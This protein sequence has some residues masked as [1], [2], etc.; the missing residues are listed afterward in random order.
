MPDLCPHG[1]AG[2]C[3]RCDFAAAHPDGDPMPP[4][5]VHPPGRDHVLCP[6][7]GCG[8]LM[9]D[10]RDGVCA[11]DRCRCGLPADSLRGCAAFVARELESE[12]GP[13][14]NARV[15]ERAAQLE[16]SYW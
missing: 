13:N 8:H 7:K 5:P 16:R 4:P 2:W 6:V 9:A 12:L 10:H 15:L 3:A 1:C 11:K 14:H